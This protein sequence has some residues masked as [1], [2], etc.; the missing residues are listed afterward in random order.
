[1]KKVVLVLFAFALLGDVPRA[2][3]AKTNLAAP[4]PTP[5]AAAA[6]PNTY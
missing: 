3:L 2:R 6:T 1:M 4:L 5:A